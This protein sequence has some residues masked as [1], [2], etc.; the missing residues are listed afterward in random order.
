MTLI[1]DK[2]LHYDTNSKSV[3][4]YLSCTGRSKHH[5]T[6][7]SIY[8]V[9]QICARRPSI[10]T[11]MQRSASFVWHLWIYEKEISYFNPG[12]MVSLISEIYTGHCNNNNNK[13]IIRCHNVAGLKLFTTKEIWKHV[14]QKRWYDYLV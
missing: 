9:K 7:S 5:C 6:L 13:S 8:A 2:K 3:D 1:T 14:Q 11:D 10:L 4:N 12:Q